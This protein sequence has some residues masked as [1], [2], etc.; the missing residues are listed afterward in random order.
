MIRLT[1]N[2]RGLR[3]IA[4]WTAAGI[5]LI[6]MLVILPMLF[7]GTPRP[8]KPTGSTEAVFPE[9]VGSGQSVPIGFNQLNEDP[10]A[11][12][13]R[14]IQVTGSYTPLEVPGCQS[15]GSPR[16]QW[17]LVSEGLQLDAVGFEGLLRRLPSG[18]LMTVEGIWRLYQGPVDCGKDTPARNVWYLQVERIL[19]PNPLFGGA[20]PDGT[21]SD[22]SGTLPASGATDATPTSA[23][24]TA[25]PLPTSSIPTA[26]PEVTATGTLRATATAR[27]STDATLTPIGTAGT[28]TRTPRVVTGTPSTNATVTPTSTGTVQPG[29]ST[30]PSANSSPTPTQTQVPVMTATAG[31]GYP[32]PSTT[33]TATPGTYP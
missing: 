19:E 11:L 26:T 18:T 17:A 3:R 21:T 6:A 4:I 13:D 8:L 15:P 16:V 10:A 30:T 2:Y 23:A 24:P 7:G 31:T 27:A 29:A 20:Q 33:A 5:I 22:S 9:P 1:N 14:R 12:R 32:G 25:T 28:P